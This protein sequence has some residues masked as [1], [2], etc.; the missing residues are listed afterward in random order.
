M[1][2]PYLPR[3]LGSNTVRNCWGGARTLQNRTST[4]HRPASPALIDFLD[5]TVPADL[6]VLAGPDRPRPALTGPGRPW[7]A[8]TGPDVFTLFCAVF[9]LVLRMFLRMFL[10]CFT[11]VFTLFFTP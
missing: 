4:A 10:H 5:F 3:R 2:S 8:R 6:S 9:T 7:P 11:D 1:T